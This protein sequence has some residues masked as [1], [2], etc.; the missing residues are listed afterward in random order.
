MF[1]FSCLVKTKFGQFGKDLEGLRT[2]KSGLSEKSCKWVDPRI[3]T[4]VVGRLA[5]TGGSCF[6]E[7]EEMWKAW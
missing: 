3:G 5:R 6:V 2:K 4:E 7:L 1:L